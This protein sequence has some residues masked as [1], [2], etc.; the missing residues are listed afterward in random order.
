MKIS[1]LV[2]VRMRENPSDITITSHSLMVRAGYIKGVA[3]G[4][5]S[6]LPPAKRVQLK[7]EKIKAF[8]YV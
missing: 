7:I 3:N 2:G 6:L 5:F 4:I 1:K 8:L